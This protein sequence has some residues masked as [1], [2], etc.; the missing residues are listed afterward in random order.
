[1]V[2]TI[3]GDCAGL[4]EALNKHNVTQTDDLNG[5]LDRLERRAAIQRAEQSETPAGRFR[6]D[7]DLADAWAPEII[8]INEALTAE[9]SR[10]LLTLITT[11]P[12]VT[13]AAVVAAPLFGAPWSLRLREVAESGEVRATLEPLDLELRAQLIQQPAQRA[14]VDL[15]AATGSEDTTPAPWWHH[16]DQ[17]PDPPPENN[18]SYLDSTFGGWNNSGGDGEEMAQ[19]RIAQPGPSRSHPLLQLLGPIELEGAAGKTPPR[20]AKQCLEYCAWLLENPGTTAMAMASALAVAEGTRRSNMSRL[21]TWLG[22]DPSGE[23]YLPDA[24]TGRITLH[25]A[26]SSDWQGFQILTSPAINRCGTSALRAALELVRGAPLADAAPGQWH[27]AEELRTDMISAIRDLGVE[28]TSRALEDHD[29]DLA[30]WA[31]SRALAAAPGDELLMTAR[32][33]TEHQAGNAAETGRLTLQVAA[34]AR[35]LGLDLDPETVNLLQEVM[36]GQVRA[37]M[38]Q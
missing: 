1:M 17:P 3:V 6:V 21:R 18:V 13:M 7:P 24:Y 28:L 15:V 5:L 9:Q 32:I 35:S 33:R 27:W 26:V 22:S 20:A 38:T 25:P 34:Q 10:R 14:V 19:T 29:L 23:P 36:E 31:A 30:R 2:L 16:G 11:A 4:P 8:L 37:R 12:P